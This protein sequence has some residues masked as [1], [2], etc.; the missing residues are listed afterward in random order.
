M[1][2]KKK[3]ERKEDRKTDKGKK[4]GWKEGR[5]AVAA[6]FYGHVTNKFFGFFCFLSF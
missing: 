1:L 6:K 4:D 3:R 5:H 2:K